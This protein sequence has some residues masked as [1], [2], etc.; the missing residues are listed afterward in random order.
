MRDFYE[1]FYAVVESSRAHALFC[2]QAFGKNLCQHGFADLDQLQAL[3][4]VAGLGPGTRALDLGCGNGMIAEYLSD[5]TGAHVTGLDY[6]PEAIRQAQER[7]GPKAWHLEFVVGDI[8]ALELPPGAFD[9]VYSID[10]LY[11]SNDYA[12]T[13]RQLAGLLRTGGQMAILFSHGWE[14][15]M[16]LERFSADTL[17]PDRTP[18]AEAL[19]ANGLPFATLDFT[20]A[21]HRLARLRK[22]VLEKLKPLFETEDLLFIYENRMAEAEGIRQAYERGLHRRYL[23]HTRV[24]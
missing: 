14:P 22:G 15:W 24:L 7:T 18:L 1:R 12:S 3:A 2:E 13:I 21:D 6:I 5:L 10:T 4:D 8:N 9:L 19:M 17:P 23:Y 20:D 16:P 11:F